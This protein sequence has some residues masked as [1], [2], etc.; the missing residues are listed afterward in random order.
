M[1]ERKAISRRKGGEGACFKACSK[2]SLGFILL[3]LGNRPISYGEKYSLSQHREGRPSQ[4]IWDIRWIT[5][6]G[7]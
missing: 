1:H 7:K 6:S 2:A 3:G 5:R 4:P